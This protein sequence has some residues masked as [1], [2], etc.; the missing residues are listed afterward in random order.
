MIEVR[1]GVSAV[2]R[3]ASS[4]V[5]VVNRVDAYPGWWRW[6]SSTRRVS[7]TSWPMHSGVT[8]SMSA[9]S[10]IEQTCRW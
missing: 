9:I 7:P 5:A 10:F 6:S 8:S 2:S 3:K 1:R 4:S